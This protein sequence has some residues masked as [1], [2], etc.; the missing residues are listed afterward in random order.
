MRHRACAHQGHRQCGTLN[1]RPWTLKS[2]NLLQVR[3][4]ELARS[5]GTG[6][7]SPALL[8]AL[9]HEVELEGVTRLRCAEGLVPPW[10]PRLLQRLL[11]LRTLNLSSCGLTA[12]PAGEAPGC[13]FNSRTVLGLGSRVQ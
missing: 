5:T 12:L 2:G 11:G 1:P 4:I 3:R 6:S 7:V 13:W 9:L 8:E 10:E